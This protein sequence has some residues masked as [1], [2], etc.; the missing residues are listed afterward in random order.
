MLSESQDEA[1]E[2]FF[3]TRF[4]CGR[5]SDQGSHR[6]RYKPNRTLALIPTLQYRLPRPQPKFQ[7]LELLYST[8]L[9]ATS[10]QMFLPPNFLEGSTLRDHG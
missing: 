2:I 5:V 6:L 4:C 10:M 3:R 8:F 7:V 9:V 1:Q